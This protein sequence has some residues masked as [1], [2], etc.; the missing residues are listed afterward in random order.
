MDLESSR[1]KFVEISWDDLEDIHRLH[2][3]PEVDEFN[4]LG[5]PGNIEDTKEIIRTLIEGQTETPRK[6][7][8]WKI[9]NKETNE[10]I[11]LAGMKLS[12]DKFRLGEIY[13]K[14]IPGYWYKG[15]ATET[16]KTLIKQGFEYFHLH[17]VEA[18]VA[19]GNTR[20]I[21]VL[22][23]A[24]MIR[25]GLR[26]KILPVRGKWMDNYHYAIVEDDPR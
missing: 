9:V 12:C 2:S 10:F 20:S 19:T 1:L 26:R 11:G 24:G 7:Y 16:A 4:T 22:E 18:G 8:T 23:K 3:L 14:L 15:Y 21:K 17:K 5:I 13:Y 25:E 6:S